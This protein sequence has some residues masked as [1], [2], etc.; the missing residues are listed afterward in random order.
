MFSSC[1][2]NYQQSNMVHRYLSVSTVLP[3]LL[4]LRILH[5]VQCI[6]S[7]TSIDWYN[8]P[9]VLS[10]FLLFRECPLVSQRQLA[11]VEL[12]IIH[13]QHNTFGMI[14]VSPLPLQYPFQLCTYRIH[15]QSLH[16]RWEM[17]RKRGQIRE[18]LNGMPNS[19]PGDLP[20]HHIQFS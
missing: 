19:L 4:Q 9:L 11:H 20:H 15:R 16:L 8:H 1:C 2:W 3:L 13:S 17:W 10:S 6:H 18:D 7:W 5:C 14:N 12:P